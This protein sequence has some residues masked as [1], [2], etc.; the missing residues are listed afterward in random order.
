MAT[1]KLTPEEMTSLRESIKDCDINL[2]GESQDWL[3]VFAD[4]CEKE[5]RETCIAMFGDVSGVSQRS[6]IDLAQ[7]ARYKAGAMDAREI[8]S[9]QEAIRLERKCEHIYNMLP[10][11]AR[12]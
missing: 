6:V 3:L 1:R 4:L 8:W 7:Y 5:L 9:I 12:W 2:D 11:K 10:E